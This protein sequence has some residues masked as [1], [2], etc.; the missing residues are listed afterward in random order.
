MKTYLRHSYFLLTLAFIFA[1]NVPARAAVFKWQGDVVTCTDPID[2]STYSCGGFRN[3]VNWDQG[4]V[5]GNGDE[6]FIDRQ[7][8]SPNVALYEDQHVDIL[9]MEPGTRIFNQIVVDLNAPEPV[10]GTTDARILIDVALRTDPSGSSVDAAVFE[11]RLEVGGSEMDIDVASPPKLNFAGETVNSENDTIHKRGPGLLTVSGQLAIDQLQIHQGI[12]RLLGGN[13]LASFTDVHLEGGTFDLKDTDEVVNRLTANAGEIDTGSGTLGFVPNQGDELLVNFR[14]TSG[15]RIE[16]LNGNTVK[17]RSSNA[18]NN[19]DGTLHIG[20]GDFHFFHSLAAV[21]PGLI[22]GP[23][24][25]LKRDVGRL[26]VSNPIDVGTFQIDDGEVRLH[27]DNLISTGTDVYLT[28]DG[29]LN[30]N[31]SKQQIKGLSGAGGTLN[32]VDRQLRFTTDS[33]DDYAGVVTGNSQSVLIKHGGEE[34]KLSG[35]TA[36]DGFSGELQVT[37]GVFN[38]VHGLGSTSVVQVL[39][40]GVLQLGQSNQAV[41]FVGQLTGGGTISKIGS[42]A[43]TLQAHELS[44][45]GGRVVVETGTFNAGNGVSASAVDFD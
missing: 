28:D 42:G 16:K 43:W 2:G 32:L 40:D 8:P 24:T 26:D 27:A 45:F 13:N 5:P 14:G 11:S 23:G 10:V 25:F 3:G 21:T 22:K 4:S 19:F 6:A 41:S 18:F 36:L 38:A 34:F 29:T 44:T 20:E 37:D 33:L 31:G 30:L 17:L 35:A 7:A 12:V 39:T 15:G 9:T 1:N